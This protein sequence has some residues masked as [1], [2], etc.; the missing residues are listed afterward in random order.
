M[1]DGF[2]PSWPGRVAAGEETAGC[3][4]KDGGINWISIYILMLMEVNVNGKLSSDKGG[5]ANTSL[6]IREQIVLIDT[7][8]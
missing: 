5:G 4:N 3:N 1:A 8:E 6:T 2:F 7:A